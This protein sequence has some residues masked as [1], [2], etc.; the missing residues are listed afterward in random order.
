MVNEESNDYGY[1]SGTSFASPHIAGVAALLISGCQKEGINFN[2]G[3]IKAAMLNGANK[4]TDSYL[5][6]AG[7]ANVKAAWNV[8]NNA[9]LGAGDIPDLVYVHNRTLPYQ[10]YIFAQVEKVIDIDKKGK[11]KELDEIEQYQSLIDESKLN[12]EQK[13]PKELYE[14]EKKRN[15][16]LEKRLQELEKQYCMNLY[17]FY[18]NNLDHKFENQFQ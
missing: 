17:G 14:E 13:T 16:N 12:R 4:M 1:A 2:P 15:D 7:M 11:L 10:N 18:L 6:G 9:A 8:I 3:M 5:Y